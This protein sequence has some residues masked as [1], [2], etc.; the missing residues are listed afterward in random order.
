MH[1]SHLRGATLRS[2]I[3]AA[4]RRKRSFVCFPRKHRPTV[5]SQTCAQAD[6][7]PSEITEFL[8]VLHVMRK[9]LL[10]LLLLLF[11]SLCYSQRQ[12]QDRIDSLLANLPNVIT[13][14]DKVN[15]LA[16]LCFTYYS[17]NPDEGIKSG[18]IGLELAEK[19]K[20]E[21]GTALCLVNIGTNFWVKSDYPKALD[22]YFRSL[23]LN[24]KL[25]NKQQVAVV[26][27]NIGIIYVNESDYSPALDFF[28]RSLKIF[29]EINDKGEIARTIGNIAGV[30][31]YQSNFHKA[32]EY[33]MKA[34]RIMEELKDT[35]G[36]ARYLHGVGED[37]MS[38]KNPSMALQ[39]FSRSLPLF[40]KLGSTH[41]IGRD[42]YTIGATYLSIVKEENKEQLNKLFG[43]SKKMALEQ[44]KMYT[45]SAL[46]MHKKM[47]ELKELSESYLQLS[48]IQVLQHNFRNAFENYKNYTDLKDSM[49][50]EEKNKKITQTAMQYEFDKKE[51]IGK[52][53]QEKKDIR[54]RNI[55]NSIL[56]GLGG[57]LLFLSVLY[58]QR[59]TISEEKRKS[60]SLLLNIL[61]VETAEELKS[62]GSA[63][64]KDFDEVTVL[65]TDFK[66][67]TNASEQMTAQEL[68]K[69]INY[70]FSRFDE[71][72]TG[73][74]IEKIKTIG[75]SYMA[76]GGLPV[77][78]KTNSVDVVRGALEIQ[79]FVLKEKEERVKTNKLF[80]E[81]RIGI[82]TGPVVAGIVGTKKFAYDIWGD[83][84]NIASRM[85]SSGEAGKVNISGA[86]YQR[87][88]DKLKCVYRG[89]IEAKNKGMIDM[90]F[91]ESSTL[92]HG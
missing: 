73:F 6:S 9:L 68:V 75:D 62:T 13:D 91:V 23:R 80:F 88:K 5:T 3:E 55:R 66:N 84:V 87:L 56:A 63:V 32:L 57:A 8:I 60:D 37:Y 64:A 33:D 15:L 35:N 81:I 17:I 19:I 59:N 65:F 67:F 48:E 22:Y 38:L 31:S 41:G 49:F 70:Y 44:A 58:R 78:N 12:G 34:L 47:R 71:I 85:E 42:F 77:A 72:I 69:E 74:N 51:A 82:H 11:Q 7:V 46:S 1:G 29:E 50:T 27:G 86:T 54:Q 14:T 76:A 30:Y 21:K 43:G 4:S 40:K 2:F 89:K 39:Y 36:I 61:P 10:Q 26:L 52:A 79:S 90:Y 28:S 20:W 53:E 45:D 16:D 18:N 25:R 92:D 24:E 83:T